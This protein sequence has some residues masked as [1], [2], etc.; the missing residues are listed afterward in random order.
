MQKSK[1]WL[2]KGSRI[3]DDEYNS[4]L[5]PVICSVLKNR[6]IKSNEDLQ[7]Y[8]YPE[9][10]DLYDPYMLPDIKE[11]VDML[12]CAIESNKKITI[13]GDYD[14]DGVTSTSVIYKCLK[15]LD[16]DVEYYIP[17][18]MEEGYGL[19]IE[20]V[21]EIIK[22]GAGLI[23]T[24]DCGVSAVEEVKH[25]REAGVD[26]I[27][28]DHHE[29]GPVLPDTVVVNPKR[30]DSEYP[31]KELAGVG[32]A[33]KIVEALSFV[34]EYIDP[35]EYLDL[36]AI[37]TIA[38]IVPLTDENR[39]IVK[40]GLDKLRETDNPGI[41]ALV[42]AANLDINN[43]TSGHIGYVLAPR[44]NAAGRIDSARVGV[45]LFTTDYYEQAVQLADK[46]CQSNK[47]RQE[48]EE[49]ILKEAEDRLSG[50]DD[51]VVVLE[52]PAWH[53]GVIGIVASK[54]VDKYCRP[55]I[56]LTKEG[57]ICRGSARSVPGFN[58]FEGLSKC[59]G[60]LVKYGGHE[61]AAG[62]SIEFDKIDKFREKINLAAYEM[63]S[64]SKPIPNITAECR[65]NV[66]DITLKLADEVEMMEPFGMENPVP[67]FVCS[68]TLID[69]IRTVGVQDKH[70]KL[71]LKSGLNSVDA[72]AFNM[73]YNISEYRKS[74]IVDIACTIGRN[75][76]N[77]RE[78][79]QLIIKDIRKS[80]YSE[81]ERDYLRSLKRHIERLCK[82]DN[83]GIKNI[84]E[85][86]TEDAGTQPQ[87]DE[88][89][90]TPGSMIFVSSRQMLMDILEYRDDFELY[91]E[92]TGNK[93]P[94]SD[95]TTVVVCP[96]AGSIC[97]EGINNI[98]IAD[99]LV[100]FGELEK[101]ISGKKINCNIC[102][103]YTSEEQCFI[104]S[105]K[106]S[107][108]DMENVYLYI[109]R[110]AKNRQYEFTME[111]IAETLMMDKLKAYYTIRALSE[112]DVFS[113][114][115]SGSGSIIVR[116]GPYNKSSMDNSYTI[117]MFETLISR[118]NSLNIL[119]QNIRG[120]H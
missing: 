96:D 98:Y 68:T 86:C 109:K 97:Y 111:E 67:V 119:F 70:L 72:I 56:L 38:D 39:I 110:N 22:S 105:I 9:L 107:R 59:S 55:V 79:P 120:K 3:F 95:K 58:I 84:G 62:L 25:C 18:R 83:T 61:M 51:F 88:I 113:A 101:Q 44:I 64:K 90:K 30:Q 24:V 32:V 102:T 73:G 63:M 94:I 47:I 28:T 75:S 13:Y 36:T 52:S 100:D 17:S 43:V 37:G 40:Y 1:R 4:G 7:K 45:E 78:D 103:L 35:Y 89:L 20:A 91:F 82:S 8:L 26:I 65:I 116:F 77:G 71:R 69:D 60:L 31:F 93:G 87:M 11:A 54:L 117:K 14:A 74:D 42:Q 21:D 118:L 46:L 99:N 81:I 108:G 23:I 112:M 29:C 33:F 16:A 5:S 49:D 15:S 41:R 48:I 19:N 76:W 114:G 85:F 50:T 27:I 104:N 57:E 53:V 80:L 12:K 2:I 6:G 10:E 92:N 66:D 106:P 34:Y 115:T